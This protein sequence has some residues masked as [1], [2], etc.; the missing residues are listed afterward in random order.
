MTISLATP[1]LSLQPHRVEDFDAMKAMWGDPAVVRFLGGVPSSEEESWARLLRYAGSWSLLGYG[2]WAVRRADSDAYI[3]DVGFLDAH[4]TGVDGFAGDPEIG[5]SLATAAH[6]QGFATEAVTAALGWGAGR[7]RR[8]VAMIAPDNDASVAVAL[9]CGF[10]H[11]LMAR[12]K[13]APIA[14][15]EYRWR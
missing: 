12:Y 6:G 9:R 7:F 14:L 8:C 10:R 13:D 3:G 2:F 5:W 1:R 15:W 4:R 11:F